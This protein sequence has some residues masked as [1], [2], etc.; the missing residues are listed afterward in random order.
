MALKLQTSQSGLA[1]QRCWSSIILALAS[2]E[3]PEPPLQPVRPIDE[4]EVAD[5]YQSSFVVSPLAGLY[6]EMQIS[7]R[8]PAEPYEYLPD[9]SVV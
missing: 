8:C 1:H 2:C 3:L 7:N 6:A 5:T 9:Q 4:I